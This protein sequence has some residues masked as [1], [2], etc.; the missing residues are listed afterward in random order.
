M[1][2]Y[3]HVVLDEALRHFVSDCTKLSRET[4]EQTMPDRRQWRI[5]SDLSA[6]CAEGPSAYV[7]A[8]V[9]TVLRPV[10]EALR[11]LE[12]DRQA[13]PMGLACSALLHAWMEHIVRSRIVFSV[14][15]GLQLGQDLWAVRD[16]VASEA[17]ALGPVP[18]GHVLALPVFLQAEEA[19]RCL[20]RQPQR[21]PTRSEMAAAH[22][23]DGR[24]CSSCIH[25]PEMSSDLGLENLEFSTVDPQ[26]TPTSEPSQP[27][28]DA[29]K[30]R[31]EQGYGP[32]TSTSETEGRH[33]PSSASSNR[34]GAEIFSHVNHQGGQH[35]L[36]PNGQR[37]KHCTLSQRCY[38]DG[39]TVR[40][41]AQLRSELPL[42]SGEDVYC[43]EVWLALRL[44]GE[45][46]RWRWPRLPC[47]TRGAESL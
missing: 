27:S 2:K 37:V 45:V 13:Q 33:F 15:G 31:K 8:L 1:V 3:G 47:C 5:S 40:S 28:P 35:V 12:A 30:P 9:A 19:V 26:V 23:L 16:F 18:C 24:C 17:C 46:R 6:G 43:P 22:L 29:V 4:L 36:Q 10:A 32:N 38:S 14:Q 7:L 34:V 25:T 44:C 39:S 20:L 21:P 42:A 11:P 41:P